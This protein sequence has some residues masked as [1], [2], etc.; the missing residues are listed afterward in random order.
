MIAMY[1]EGTVF[2][3]YCRPCWYSDKWDALEYGR[4]YD[5]SK[6]FFQQFKELQDVV[7]R[8]ALQV[9]NCVNCE[10]AN[11]MANCKNCYLVVGA[12]DD[13][14]CYYGYRIMNSRNL[15]D[16]MAMFRS[17]LG[18]EAIG[19]ADSARL[20]FAHECADSLDLQFCYD[21]H[22]A[23]NCF[24]SASLRRGSYYFRN[25][26]LSKGEYETRMASVD[27]GSYR[28][29]QELRQEFDA[30]R[31][32]SVRRFAAAKNVLNS[33]GHI[34]HHTKNCRSCFYAGNLENCA[35]CVFV[36]DSKDTMDV[37]NGCCTMELIY[38]VSTVGLNTFR[39]ALSADIWPEARDVMYS[40]TC[41]NGVANLFGC[42]SVRKKQC[43]I[44][45]KQYTKEAYEALVARIIAQM[46]AMP[47][48]DGKGR[49][50]R[51]GE[52]FPIELSPFPYNDT[53]AQ[54]YFPLIV[55][56]ATNQGYHWREV[57]RQPHAV[58]LP[59]SQLPDHIRD[60]TDSILNEV[61]GC[62]HQAKCNERCT[63][64]F[65]IIRPELEFYRTMNL[66]LPRLCPNC[67]HYQ[68]LKYENPFVLWHRQCAC[69]YAVRK[70]SSVHQ[71]HPEG[72]C[73]NE[74]ETSYSPERKEVVYCEE[75]YNAEVI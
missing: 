31:E 27:T 70:N 19:C 68:R 43:C 8:I 23:Q 49:I 14:D 34:L 71:H 33:T 1:P 60:V 5:F 75:C 56:E 51:Y 32:K 45:N 59:S 57:E 25:E 16:T 67:R 22:G 28:K 38:E 21:V 35:Y 53:P 3:V 47:Y 4:E 73:P 37:N 41:R 11:Q 74:F 29:L 40:N 6:P 50:Y 58:T 9:D 36:N 7:P 55:A 39:I 48:T 13:E 42:I 12:S 26:R 2:P 61:V 15:V 17:E 46:D 64:A 44:L 65:R 30:L 20:R 62:E 54:D 52:F 66:P 10:Y 72:R 63:G 69:D 18:Y 24:M